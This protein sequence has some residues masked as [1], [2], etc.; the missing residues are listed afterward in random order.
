MTSDHMG[1]VLAVVVWTKVVMARWLWLVT[2]FVTFLV[3]TRLAKTNSRNLPWPSGL[4]AWLPSLGLQVWVST[5]SPSRLAWLLY[6]CGALLRAVFGQ[7]K[8]P[9]NYLWREGKSSLQYALSCWKRCKTLYL[10]SFLMLSHP[11]SNNILD[12]LPHNVGR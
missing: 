3:Q 11:L 4:N 5:G 12:C 1:L 2:W 6:K 9:W 8:N 7:R 10:P